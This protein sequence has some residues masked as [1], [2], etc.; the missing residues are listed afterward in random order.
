M[1]QTGGARSQQEMTDGFWQCV[2]RLHMLK[3]TCAAV[4]RPALG[5]RGACATPDGY[6]HQI[7]IL[8]PIR[9]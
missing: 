8:G 9:K 5:D 1:G 4:T 6:S 2:S 3:S 7:P